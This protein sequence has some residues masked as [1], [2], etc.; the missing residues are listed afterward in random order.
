MEKLLSVIVPVYGVEDYLNRCVD[1][2]LG[3][4]YRNLELILVDDGS[5]DR[6]GEICDRYAAA[7][8]RVRVIHK[9]NGGLSSARNI[10]L[11]TFTGDYVTFVDSDDFIEPETL[12][13]MAEALEQHEADIVCVG[14]WEVDSE[15]GEKTLG[16]CPSRS[17]CVTGEEMVGKIFLW[18]GCDSAVCDK[19]FRRE[20]LE[21]YRFPQ[22]KVCEDV[23]VTYRIILE[24]ERVY[25]MD[26]PLYNYFQR[27]GSISH[28][29]L[30]DN[31]FHFSQHTKIIY[32]YIRA[33][34]P[35]IEPQA[36]YLRVRSLENILLLQDLAGEELRRKYADRYRQQV[37]ELR[38]HLGFILRYPRF[39][40]KDRVRD[41]LLVLGMYR[42]LRPYFTH[43]SRENP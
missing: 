13:L 37:R 36:R 23:A 9:E 16:I 2:I 5:P 43:D 25:L 3:Q 26:Q 35:N 42:A 1:S 19:L 39:S 27:P 7:D 29:A 4:S 8:S 10:A 21:H 12:R 17:Q 31:S 14:N 6:S 30:S 20:L 18:D 28:S 34:A 32:D 24:A 15:T 40:K 33:N 41:I 11:D 38:T 22:G